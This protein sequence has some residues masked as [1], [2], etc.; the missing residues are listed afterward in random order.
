MNVFTYLL[1]VYST[2][3]QLAPGVQGQML[4]HLMSNELE[5]VYFEAN[6]A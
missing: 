3:L 2:S 4:H 1:V 5:K 6:V